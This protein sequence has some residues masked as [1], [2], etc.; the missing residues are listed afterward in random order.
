MKVYN[1]IPRSLVGKIGDKVGEFAHIK[2]DDS[3]YA[4]TTISYEHHE[5]HAGSYFEASD[6][7]ANIGD[8]TTPAD[9]IQLTFLTPATK[10]IHMVIHA[11]CTAAAVYTFTEAYTGAGTNG[12]SVTAYNRNRIL[13]DHKPSG[14]VI[15]KQADA[16]VTGGTVLESYTITDGKFDGG[17]TRA[18]QEWILK[19]S[20]AYAVAVYLAAA[21]VASIQL[22]WYE[23]TN[24]S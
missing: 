7:T 13:H 16:V 6:T 24:K 3:T 2:I 15:E 18:S 14:M 19:K 17:E 23:H 10:E 1:T 8:E 22:S 11:K 9:A 21:G 5:V 20:T 12:D 4:I